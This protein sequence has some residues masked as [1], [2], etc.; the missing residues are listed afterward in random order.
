MAY[1]DQH[2][3]HLFGKAVH[4]YRLIQNGDRIVVAVSGGKDSITLLYLLK[5]RLKHVPINY[6]I[7]AVYVN[8]GFSEEISDSLRIFFK[9]LGVKFKIIDTDH[10]IRAHEKSNRTH[11]CFLCS[12]LR[13]MTIFKYAWEHGFRKIATGHNQDDFIETFLMNI[14]YSGQISSIVPKQDF[15][16]GKITIIRPLILLPSHKIEK[17]VRYKGLP[18]LPN[19]CPSSKKSSR[20]HI[21]KLLEELYRKNDKI[22]G[23]IFRAMSHI[24][25]DYL[26]PPID[27]E[28]VSF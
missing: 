4:C 28:N 24:N 7:L 21:R 25:L 5:E 8:L 13:K 9:D 6:E 20:I 14:C 19:P 15:F 17:F 11:P 23:N 2:V 3:R 18:D 12:R 27:C 22:R 26:P 1:I 10:G 16:S